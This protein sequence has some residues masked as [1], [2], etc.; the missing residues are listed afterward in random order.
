MTA[1][2]LAL[3]VFTRGALT[4][5]AAVI[6]LALPHLYGAPLPDSDATAAPPA[7]ARQF[8]VTA[9]VANF[10]FWAALGAAAGYFYSRLGR[11]AA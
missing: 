1:G 3:L 9:T 2:A 4:T 6:L 5:V 7:L 10:L 11:Q 8:V